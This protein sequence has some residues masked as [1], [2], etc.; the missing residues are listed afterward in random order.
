[1]EHTSAPRESRLGG[2][3]MVVCPDFEGKKVEMLGFW[4]EGEEAFIS[5]SVHRMK[6]LVHG[7]IMRLI[8][9]LLINHLTIFIKAQ[10]QSKAELSALR[11]IRRGLN[12][13]G[14]KPPDFWLSLVAHELPP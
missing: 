13:Q 12:N 6:Q 14:S 5:L 8:V 4:K 10:F 7:L 1:M 2:L 9:M 11:S 3:M